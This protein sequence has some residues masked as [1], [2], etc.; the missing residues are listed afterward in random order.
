MT[1]NGTNIS[2]TRGDTESITVRMKSGGTLSPGDIIDFTVRKTVDSAVVL[3]KRITEFFDDS[4][5][6]AINHQ[7]T[8][9][10]DFGTYRYDIQLTD[11]GGAVTTLVK[12]AKFTL[13]EEITYGGN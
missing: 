12:P 3:H 2:M 10:M 1:L 8:S 5:V 4:A 6:I 11:A 7:D 9:S 13:T